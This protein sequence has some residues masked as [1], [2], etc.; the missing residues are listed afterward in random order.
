VSSTRTAPAGTALSQERFCS[1]PEYERG[2]L[3]NLVAMRCDLLE[4]PNDR[5]LINFLQ[6]VSWS[7][8][9]LKRVA[10]ELLEQ[11]PSAFATRQMHRFGSEGNYSAEQVQKV[12]GE[13]PGGKDRFPLRDEETTAERERA[14]VRRLHELH[15]TAYSNIYDDEP[16][17]KKTRPSS[18]PAATFVQL[19]CSA[20]A[21]QLEEQ[22]KRL[23]LDPG[24]CLAELSPWY[25][26]DLVRILREYRQAWSNART[27][28]AVV[29]EVGKL[30]HDSLEYSYSQKCLTVTEGLE[31]IGKTCAALQWCDL[32]PG[33]ARY[34]QVPPTND[35]IG[36]FQAIAKA[37]GVSI[38]L[39]SKAQE[40]RARIETV[41]QRGH[42]ML[43]FDDSHWLWPQSRY[44]DALP[45]RITWLMTALVDKGIGVALLTTPQFFESQRALVRKTCWRHHQFE[46]R[47]GHYEYLPEELSEPDLTAVAKWHLPEGDSETIFGLV[48]YA[49]SS[50]RYLQGIKAVV[51]RA[52]YEVEKAGRAKVTANDIR[53]VITRSAIPSDNGLAAAIAGTR[54]TPNATSPVPTPTPADTELPIRRARPAKRDR[55]RLAE[56]PRFA[57]GE[58]DTT[59]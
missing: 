22:I 50:G 18:Y 45:A 32:H 54:R 31:R 25:C 23:C 1:S 46:G 30:V 14:A 16:A 12:R 7:E 49:Q 42:L 26:P 48:S 13:I 43:I 11:F 29:T 37:L 56:Q 39:N 33:R 34:V 51:Q 57:I 5:E 58:V 53:R 59:K 41:L 19:C 10:A 21:D 8:G 2:L 40:L 17:K 35:D 24:L 27:A 4:D 52:R 9:G 47:I 36:F 44:R 55:S 15:K 38:N 3:G 28:G 20:A 6:L